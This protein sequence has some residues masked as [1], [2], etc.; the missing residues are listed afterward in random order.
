M[1][2]VTEDFLASLRPGAADPTAIAEICVDGD[3]PAFDIEVVSD[4]RVGR[5]PPMSPEG[6]SP[7]EAETM[8]DELIDRFR[9]LRMAF[10]IPQP[11]HLLINCGDLIVGRKNTKEEELCRV[12]SAYADICLPAFRQLQDAD[13]AQLHKDDSRSHYAAFLTVPGNEDAYGGGG[14]KRGP[15]GAPPSAVSEGGAA[16]NYPYYSHFVSSLTENE[17][18]PANPQLHPVV[19]VFCILPQNPEMAG[20]LQ[21]A[22]LAYI[23]VIGFDSNDIQYHHNLASDYGQISGEQLQWS[24]R[25]VDELRNGVALSTPLY[26][27]AVTH[28]NL[29]PLEDRVVYPPR[30]RETTFVSK[31]SEADLP[32]SRKSA[33]HCRGFASQTISSQKAVVATSN[34]SGFL[35]HCQKLRI[36]SVLHGNMHQRAATTLIETPLVAGRPATELASWR[37]PHSRPDA[38]PPAWLGSASISGRARRRWPSA[39]TPDRTATAR[40]ARSRSSARSSRRPVSAAAEHRLYTK[41]TRL[42]AKALRSGPVDK[43]EKVQEYADYVAAV[44]TGTATL[45]SRTRTEPPG[46]WA[47]HTAE[48]LLPPPSATRGRGSQLRDASKSPHCR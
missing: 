1:H 46:P 9:Q 16:S 28:H 43:R 4:L 38:R 19:S 47:A 6:Y 44:W 30:G 14:A 34:A 15:W 12:R 7:G 8:R 41:I 23:A 20:G 10:N 17:M 11:A 40:A 39:T 18:P 22:P 32:T 13:R 25:L 26:V 29:L 42:V 31:I 37:R 48:S 36:S 3:S 5:K 45:Q 24:Q 35:D 27:I 33:T 21:K 2:F